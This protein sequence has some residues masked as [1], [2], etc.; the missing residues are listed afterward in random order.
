MA[1]AQ[2]LPL[3][4]D[5]EIQTEAGREAGFGALPVE[6]PHGWE[7][8]PI[9]YAVRMEAGT[10]AMLLG[11]TDALLDPSA[12]YD[13]STSR[14]LLRRSQTASNSRREGVFEPGSPPE[15]QIDLTEYRGGPHNGSKKCPVFPPTTCRRTKRF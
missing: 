9:F 15:P 13:A 14:P 4:S 2:R 7:P 3:L 11:R 1:N 10:T 12:D 5:D 6:L 8:T